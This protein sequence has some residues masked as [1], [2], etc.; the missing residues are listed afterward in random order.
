MGI[1]DFHQNFN[2]FFDGLDIR[3]QTEN[4]TEQMKLHSRIGEGS[5]RRFVPRAD[6]GVAIAEFKLHHNHKVSLHTEAA[7]VELSYCIQGTREIDVSGVQYQVAPGSYTLQ[8]V[9]P[10]RAS[11]HFSGDQSF[12]MLSIGIPVS[13]FHR[14]ME[15]AG[16]ARTIDFYRIIGKHSYRMFQETIDP[17]ASVLLKQM[18]Q[19]AIGQGIRNL[20]MEYRLLELMSLAFRSFLLDGNS[21]STRLSKTDMARIEQARKIILERMTEP[22]SL[23][24]L[25]R[26]IGLNDYKLKI[27]FKEMYGR[28][29]FGYLRDQ[30]LEKAYHSL[31]GGSTSVIEVSCAVGYSNPSYFAEAF[32][33]KYG[34]NPGEFVRRK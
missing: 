2:L 4:R 14:F 26:L 19:A 32:R 10:A 29:V 30:R 31:Q 23:L 18:L 21:A 12:Q 5:V 25:S 13:T 24:E 7:M 22:P 15:E 16:G 27:G 11:M 33:E 6:M 3:R 17:A 8:F 34:V 20:E 1:A 9:N 28:T